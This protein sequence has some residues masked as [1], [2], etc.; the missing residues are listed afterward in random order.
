M[1][2]WIGPVFLLLL[3]GLAFTY[4]ALPL[5]LQRALGKV[6][7]RLLYAIRFRLAV[8]QRNLDV[9]FSSPAE[10]NRRQ[11]I[12][13]A[14]Y[15]HFGGLILDILMLLGPLKSYVLKNVELLGN[16]NIDAA[17]REGRGIL[18]LSSHLGNWEMMA[19]AGGLHTRA[20]LLMVTKRIKPDWLH[21]A[22]ERG[23]SR[24]KVRA[25]YEPQTLKDV[26]AH[27]KKGEA[28]GFVLDQ[29]SGPPVGVRVPF[30]NVPV[31][32]P[33]IVAALAKR[34]DAA[35]LPVETYRRPDGRW[36]VDVGPPVPWQAFPDR[37]YELA[38]NTAYYTSI[39]EK[40]IL[41]HPEQ[42]MWTHRRFKGDLSPLREGEWQ[43]GRTRT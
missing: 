8:V 2:K 21:R 26:L 24:C 5:R 1:G 31:G 19:A 33:L 17:L 23:R 10:E 30:F 38:A 15:D 27:L 34:T 29:Y 18:F 6:L 4:G 42:W 36:V 22:I 7:G 3:R 32:T 25:T 14:S 35:V 39:I 43:E 40:M 13:R 9:A 11:R 12:L 37:S 20:K 28:V 41:R 16:E